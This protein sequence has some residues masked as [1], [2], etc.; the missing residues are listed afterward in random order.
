MHLLLQLHHTKG[1][2]T[3][4]FKWKYLAPPYIQACEILTQRVLLQAAIQ[5]F[6]I[7][8]QQKYLATPEIQGCCESSSNASVLAARAVFGREYPVF[9]VTPGHDRTFPARWAQWKILIS[10]RNAVSPLAGSG[11]AAKR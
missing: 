1:S 6:L 8:F 2:L 11:T 7:W 3:P 4:G 10:L 9:Y 5:R